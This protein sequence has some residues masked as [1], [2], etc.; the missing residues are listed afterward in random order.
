MSNLVKIDKEYVAVLEF[1][2][3]AEYFLQSIEK[4]IGISE[5]DLTKAM[6]EKLK[7]SLP[8]I[9]EIE[10]ELNK[11]SCFLTNEKNKN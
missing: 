2:A 3:V 11:P 5:Y 9:E 8:T 7:T 10:T 1:T 4:S 6:H